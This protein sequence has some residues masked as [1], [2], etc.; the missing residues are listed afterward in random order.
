M[1]FTVYMVPFFFCWLDEKVQTTPVQ[2][3]QIS[4]GFGLFILNEVLMGI[5]FTWF[6]ANYNWNMRLRVNPVASFHM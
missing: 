6:S 5:V 2:L 3:S 1:G 4:L